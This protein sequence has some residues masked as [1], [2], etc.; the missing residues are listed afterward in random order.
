MLTPLPPAYPPPPALSP[1]PPPA[2]TVVIVT[3]V[4]PD[5]IVHVVVAPAV[6]LHVPVR[7]LGGEG[8]GRAGAVAVARAVAVA[9]AVGTEVGGFG[10][11]LPRS[12]SAFTVTSPPIVSVH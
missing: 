9:D 7:E 4:T 10:A 1:P 6:P 8:E 2:P 12:N 5:G 11:P 3:R